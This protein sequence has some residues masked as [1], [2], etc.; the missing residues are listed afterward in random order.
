MKAAKSREKDLLFIFDKLFRHFGPRRWW[1]GET[2]FEIVIGAILTQNTSWKNVEKA[3]GRLK[4]HDLLQPEKLFTIPEKE[5]AL[6]I[7]SSGYYNQKA[8][9]IREFLNFFKSYSFSFEDMLSV[10]KGRIREELLAVRGIGQE[11]ADSII[12]Y[13]LEKPVFVIDA[14][15][16]RIFSRLGYVD[17]KISYRELQELFVRNLPEDVKLYN[18][19]HALIV[20]FGHNI[21]RKKPLCD[22]CFLRNRC[23]YWSMAGKAARGSERVSRRIAVR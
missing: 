13:A 23:S 9:K 20:A 16:K 6:L 22:L 19:Y 15:T 7:R 4:E 17:E 14:Y 2:K 21:C 12:L 1:P 18:E 10:D 3:I 5:L 8:K 11:T